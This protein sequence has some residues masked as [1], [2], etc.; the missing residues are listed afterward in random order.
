MTGAR[1]GLRGVARIERSRVV[2]GGIGMV[3]RRQVTPRWADDTV[4]RH[5]NGGDVPPPELNQEAGRVVGAV[6]V[7]KYVT[8]S[9]RS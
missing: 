2:A 7:N 6:Q 5:V 4:R 1:E 9:N 8:I 3:G